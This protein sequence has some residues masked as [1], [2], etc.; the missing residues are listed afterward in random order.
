[1]SL[2]C[3]A[4]RYF[5]TL[6]ILILGCAAG[7][8]VTVDD[9]FAGSYSDP[10]GNTLPYRLYVPQNYDS[11]KTYPL[12][13]FLHGAG[14]RGTDNRLQLTGQT[15]PLVF[16]QPQNQA[17][18]PMFMLAPQAPTTDQ[19][20][21]VPFDQGSYSTTA[22]PQSR[23]LGTAI[24]LLDSLKTQYSLDSNRLYLTGLSMGGYGTWDAMLRHPDLFAAGIPIA[25]GGDPSRAAD[26]VN[27][28]IWAFH[29]SEDTVVPVSGSR[30]MIAGLRAA[31]GNPLYTEYPGVGHFSW[32]LAY[33]TP[34]LSDWLCSQNLQAQAVPEHSQTSAWTMGIIILALT[35]RTHSFLKPIR[36]QA[37][38][39]KA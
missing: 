5:F 29:G 1:V 38:K 36:Q 6:A 10:S 3:R 13:M 35:L 34:G 23:S 31:G 2:I 37:M 19:W 27:R 22:V 39:K 20:V 7:G 26:I 25:G 18:C 15:A 8:Q 17:V 9:F 16:V 11:S 14:E 12:V 21:D 33:S 28:G 24:S 32:D 30:D 4:S